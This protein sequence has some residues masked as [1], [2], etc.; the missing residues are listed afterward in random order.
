MQSANTDK[1]QQIDNNIA[2]VSVIF[3]AYL[4]P[5][6]AQWA[7]QRKIQSTTQKQKSPPPGPDSFSFKPRLILIETWLELVAKRW[8]I[9]NRARI[10][11]HALV[12]CAPNPSCPASRA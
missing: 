10:L 12:R 9:S 3:Q 11:D 5:G 6:L 1:D 4:D 2:L 8:R 7:E